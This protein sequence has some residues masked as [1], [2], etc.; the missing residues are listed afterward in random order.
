MS[1][2]IATL[3]TAVEFKDYLVSLGISLPFDEN[4]RSGP[5]SP[6]A[7]ARLI[8]GRKAGN[9]FAVLPMEGFDGTTDGKPTDVSTRRWQRF[10]MSGAKLIWG[11]ATAIRPDGRGNPHQFMMLDSTVDDMAK[12]REATVK[13][14]QKSYGTSADLLIGIQLTHTGRVAYPHDQKRNEPKIVYHHPL[15]DARAGIP[16]DYPVLTDAEI[17]GI[18]EDFIKASVLA[19]KAGFDFV[20]I[21]SCHGF[22]GHELL[23]AVDRPGR[24]GGSLENRTRFLR[25]IVSGIRARTSGLDIAIRFSATDFVPFQPGKE[26]RGEP[27]PFSGKYPYAFGGD[28]TGLGIDLTEPVAFLDLLKKLGINL[29]SVSVG[30]SYNVHLLRPSAIPAC[31]VYG[32]PEDPLV[33]VARLIDVTADLKR[34]RPGFTYVGCG[35]SYLHQWMPNVAQGVVSQGKADIAGIGRLVLCYPE[36]ASDILTGKPIDR[37]RLCLTC[38]DCVTAYRNGLFAGC[39]ALDDYY[40]KS[41]AG[42]QLKNL[43]MSLKSKN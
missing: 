25:E 39:Y 17:T 43:K 21:K 41:A 10:G 42:E 13:A 6:L 5:D 35:Y 40:K 23:S 14:H 32:N 33:S 8:N 11:E 4:V 19:K 20:D 29:V 27:M 28:G 12:L 26:G 16:A 15:L 7:Q 3:K 37:R 30:A 18:A 1:K 38:S 34:L 22:I 24:Y 31:D 2:K 36:I 9:S